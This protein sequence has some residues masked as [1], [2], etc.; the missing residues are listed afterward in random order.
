[1]KRKKERKSKMKTF[2]NCEMMLFKMSFSFI[3]GD[4]IS[5]KNDIFYRSLIF[6]FADSATNIIY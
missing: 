1:M 6:W 3:S 4:I 5:I 2:K